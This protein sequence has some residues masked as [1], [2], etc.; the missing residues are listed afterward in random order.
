MQA[1]AIA[2]PNI[3]LI[4]Y[5]GKRDLALN[6]PAVGSISITL[7]AL[8]TQVSIDL[9]ANQGSDTLIVN[10]DTEDQQRLAP[11]ECLPGSRYWQA[12]AVCSYRE[13]QQFP[14]CGRP[15]VI[16][17]G[18]RCGNACSRCGCRPGASTPRRWPAWPGRHRDRLRAH[19][20]ADFAELENNGDVIQL[21]ALCDEHAWPL[22]VVVAIT[23][24][25]PKATGSTEAMEISR[26]TSPFYDAWIERQADDLA[27]ARNGN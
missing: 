18:F 10:G 13:P 12:A 23:E 15:R 20:S 6:L 27:M 26:K 1:T 14:D 22:K 17:I 21:D 11:D 19:C 7:D 4:K 3:A 25:G 5:W 24:T 9:G 8:Q 2:Q 16:R